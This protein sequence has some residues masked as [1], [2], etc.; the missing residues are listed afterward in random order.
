MQPFSVWAAERIQEGLDYLVA[1][2]ALVL[3]GVL[4]V[5]L[6]FAALRFWLWVDVIRHGRVCVFPGCGELIRGRFRLCLNHF[7]AASRYEWE[8]RDEWAAK[9]AG[10]DA[11]Y[12]YILELDGGKTLYAGQTRNLLRRLGEHQSGTTK[13]TA[14]RDPKLV[15]FEQLPSRQAAVEREADMKHLIDTQPRPVRRMIEAFQRR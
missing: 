2:W 15:W 1:E 13:T 5:S 10:C 12:V 8:H 7:R 11:F 4:T 6:G 14:G 3:F 9:D